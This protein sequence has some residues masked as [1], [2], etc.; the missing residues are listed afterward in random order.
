MSVRLAK[1]RVLRNMPNMRTR[2]A[3]VDQNRIVRNVKAGR[4]IKLYRGVAG[5]GGRHIK[6]GQSWTTSPRLAMVFA[7]LG[8]SGKP[9][10]YSVKIP[11]SEF[12]TAGR[13]LALSFHRYNN[14][15]RVGRTRILSGDLL[16]RDPWSLMWDRV[17]PYH[18]DPEEDALEVRPNKDRPDLK[19]KIVGFQDMYDNWR[20]TRRFSR[21]GGGRPTRGGGA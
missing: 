11:A 3:D 13:R 17:S 19:P 5:A 21:S 18:E 9:L 8:S 1:A 14:P 2:T 16:K 4:P 7:E 12:K 15:R 20:I 10:L 6:K